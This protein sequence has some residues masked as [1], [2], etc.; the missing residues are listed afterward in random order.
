MSQM[1]LLPADGDI[2][3]LWRRHIAH[4]STKSAALSLTARVCRQYYQSLFA[5]AVWFFGT[6]VA[7][8]MVCMERASSKEYHAKSNAFSNA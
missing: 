1:M 5:L 8:M 7:E 4:D 6:H 3:R 2:S